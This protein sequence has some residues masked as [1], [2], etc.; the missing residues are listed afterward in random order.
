MSTEKIDHYKKLGEESI[1]ES[2]FKSMAEVVFRNEKI[3]K[4]L[5]KA[6]SA[7]EFLADKSFAQES[8]KKE[9]RDQGKYVEKRATQRENLLALVDNQFGP[10]Y[11]HQSKFAKAFF[12]GRILGNSVDREGG[13]NY[14]LKLFVNKIS[15][16]NNGEMPTSITESEFENYLHTDKFA[17]IFMK[18]SDVGAS[19][20]QYFVTPDRDR[21]ESSFDD[22][23]RKEAFDNFTELTGIKIVSKKDKLAEIE[24]EKEE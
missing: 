3:R 6:I 5:L 22:S 20:F 13:Y 24:A 16:T 14:F 8:L 10:Y 15:K 18:L 2:P 1:V 7:A 23:V 19:I 21:I 4:G 11:E 9:Y 12:G 17:N